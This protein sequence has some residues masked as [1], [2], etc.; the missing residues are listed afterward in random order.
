MSEDLEK[1]LRRVPSPNKLDSFQPDY[2]PSVEN[3]STPPRRDKLRPDTRQRYLKIYKAYIEKHLT[4]DQLAKKFK[5]N[6][7]TAKNAVKWATFY[8][9]VSFKPKHIQQQLHDKMAVQLQRL[10]EMFSRGRDTGRLDKNGEPIYK[11]L[12]IREGL[13]VVAEIRRCIKLVA[14]GQGALTK[15]NGPAPGQGEQK[16]NIILPNTNAGQGVQN[17]VTVEAVNDDP[18]DNS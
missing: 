14:Q 17:A 10:E 16:I 13:S 9:Q 11:P 18:P 3:Y 4:Y 15:P 7:C 6:I 5:C 1:S 12:N 8:H 2:V